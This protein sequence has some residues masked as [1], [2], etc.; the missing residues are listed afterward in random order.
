[1]ANLAQLEVERGD[2]LA[3]LDH[4]GLGIRLMHDAGNIVTIRSPLTNLAI[5]LDRL[6]HYEPAAVIAGFATSPLT[7]A[8][9]PNINTAIAHLRGVLGGAAQQALARKGEVMSTAAMV[10][11]AYDQIDQ[12]RTELNAVSN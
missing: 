11:Y 12:A 4:I 5:F 6:G 1:M 8:S 2:P 3:A 10:S 7:V 9:F